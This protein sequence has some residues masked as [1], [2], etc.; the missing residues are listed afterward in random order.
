MYHFGCCQTRG[1]CSLRWGSALGRLSFMD[2]LGLSLLTKQ[3]KL[4]SSTFLSL[5]LLLLGNHAVQPVF[6]FFLGNIFWC[7]WLH[8]FHIICFHHRWFRKNWGNKSNANNFTF[9]CRLRVKAPLG[10][11][12]RCNR[13]II[14]T[15]LTERGNIPLL[16]LFPKKIQ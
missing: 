8:R 12:P 4:A 5:F 6:E 10:F 9:V 3:P 2:S 11:V 15:F 16:F 7:A 13:A 1:R 14:T